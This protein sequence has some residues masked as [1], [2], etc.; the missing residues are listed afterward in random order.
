MATYEFKCLTCEQ[1]TECKDRRF[2]DNSIPAHCMHC[3]GTD[4]QQVIGSNDFQLK[5][6]GWYKPG[7]YGH[8][9]KMKERK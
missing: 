2:G 8:N 3:E 1:K 5:G 9:W 4:M 6:E 7:H